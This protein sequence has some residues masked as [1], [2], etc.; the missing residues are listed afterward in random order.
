MRRRSILLI[1]HNLNLF[2]NRGLV[3][4]QNILDE[5]KAYNRKFP[6]YEIGADDLSRSRNAV[7]KRLEESLGTMGLKKETIPFIR[8]RQI[9]GEPK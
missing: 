2:N 9:G 6:G 7:A 3:E 8:A 5:I 4:E 1:K